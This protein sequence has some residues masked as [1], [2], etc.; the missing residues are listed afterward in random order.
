V[1]KV[2]IRNSRENLRGFMGK[3][4]YVGGRR[5]NGISNAEARS[6]GIKNGR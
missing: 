4:L 6:I 3:I 5:E 1:Y 2:S